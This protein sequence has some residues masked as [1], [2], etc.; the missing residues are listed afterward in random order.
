VPRNSVRDKIDM[1]SR[2]D[3]PLVKSTSEPIGM[4]RMPHQ[5]TSAA[6]LRNTSS[7]HKNQNKCYIKDINASLNLPEFRSQLMKEIV[8][9]GRLENPMTLMQLE[10]I[11]NKFGMSLLI[12]V[13]RLFMDNA[14]TLG[15][16]EM[17]HLRLHTVP[18]VAKFNETFEEID[19]CKMNNVQVSV[20]D[21]CKIQLQMHTSFVNRAT[22]VSSCAT[23]NVIFMAQCGDLGTTPCD[24][25][26]ENSFFIY[27][28]SV[29]EVT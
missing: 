21:A 11:V 13:N 14:F 29:F 10:K 5:A 25:T 16:R 3:M 18:S 22:A 1:F 27:F 20:I 26:T 9:K 17:A 24:A 12:T 4:S 15:G 6:T 23:I 7:V 28:T 19:E 2:M 8:V